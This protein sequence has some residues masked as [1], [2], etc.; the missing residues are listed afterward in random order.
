MSLTVHQKKKDHGKIVEK[1]VKID[2]P[3]SEFMPDP[4][5]MNGFMLW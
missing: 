4:A 5:M 2:D 1:D 3:I